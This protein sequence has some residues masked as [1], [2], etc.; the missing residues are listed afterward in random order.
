MAYQE[1]R[2]N[3]KKE[4]RTF[5]MR[6]LATWD[7]RRAVESLGYWATAGLLA[8]ADKK[9]WGQSRRTGKS[10]AGGAFAPFSESV[11]LPDTWSDGS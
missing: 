11:D 4:A 6:V 9:A 8:C 2:P 1:A 7:C 10:R 3:G 5:L